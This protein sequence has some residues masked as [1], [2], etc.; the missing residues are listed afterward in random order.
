VT[1]T[2][3]SPQDLGSLHA[4]LAEESAD[5]APVD[6]GP[7]PAAHVVAVLVAHDGEQWLR[8][9]LNSVAAQTR[10][11]DVVIV[12]D[13]G[14]LDATPDLLRRAQDAGAVDHVL[15]VGRAVGFGEAVRCALELPEAR[16]AGP[17]SWLWMLHD[18]CAAA[19]SALEELLRA[20]EISSGA[21]VLGPKVVDWHDPRVLVEVGVTL[22]RAGHRHTG[23]EGRELDQGQADLTRTVLAVGTAAALVRREVWDALGGLDPAL[24]LFRDDVDLGW[25]VAA[26]GSRCE[27]VPAAVVRHVRAAATGRRPTAAVA[28]PPRRADRRSALWVL[29]ANAGPLGLL[30]VPV[31]VLSTLLRAVGDLVTRRPHHARDEFGA[32]WHLIAALPALRR[33]RAQRAARRTVPVRRVKQLF[34]PRGTSLR[35]R[36]SQAGDLLAGTEDVEAVAAVALETGPGEEDLGAGLGQDDGRRLARLLL[37]PA[38]LIPTGLTLLTLVALRHLLGAGSLVGGRLLPAPP[39]AR[40]LWR[41]WA[42]TW[43]P[44]PSGGSGTPSPPFTPWLGL[45]STLTLGR[46]SLAVDLLVLGAVPMAGLVAW[47]ASRPLGIGPGL[48]TW[49]ALTWA[50]SPVATGAVSGGRFDLCVALVFLPWMISAGA[51]VLTADPYL[52]GWRRTWSLALLLAMAAAFHPP[53]WLIAAVLGSV[54]VLLTPGARAGRA[55]VLAVLL[56]VPVLL[57]LPW[58][59]ALAHQPLDLLVGLGRSAGLST[60]AS[61]D[62]ASGP[63]LALLHPGGPGL[64]WA[65][66]TLPLLLAAVVALGLPARARRLAGYVAVATALVGLA[67]AV[68]VSR[69]DSSLPGGEQGYSWP[70]MGIA[71]A[72]LGVLAAAMLAG[73]GLRGRMVLRSFSLRTVAQ[74]MLAATCA[75]VPLV[76]AG[77]W[78]GQGPGGAGRAQEVGRRTIALLPPDVQADAAAV[79]DPGQRVLVLQRRADGSLRYDLG[80]LGGPLLGD[81]DRV[82]PTRSRRLLDAV[83]RDLGATRG[84]DADEVLTTFDIRTVVVSGRMRSSLTDALDSQPSL[85]RRDTPYNISLWQVILP[86][87]RAAVLAPALASA[88][89]KPAGVGSASGRGPDRAALASTPPTLL[90]VGGQDV[91]ARIPAGEPGRL[92]VLS[93]AIS[94]GWRATLDGHP[95]VPTLAWG[96][97]QGF[98]LPTAG[99]RLEVSRAEGSHQLLLVLQVLGLLVVLV[100]ALPSSGGDDETLAEA[101]EPAPGPRAP[102]LAP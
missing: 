79:G 23:L 70:G 15:T 30:G 11:P 12:V 52:M 27:I 5:F 53:L 82:I 64:P 21:S 66:L 48:R 1:V 33:A 8:G 77:F 91:R 51:R 88:A 96:W 94:G 90:R 9:C 71:L 17:G 89:L 50:L 92:L 58:L 13:T 78:L 57:A 7:V 2:E 25:R 44:G 65:P 75:V 24:P 76:L 80:R 32:A 39:G 93:E 101:I 36:I 10:V 83:V 72:T 18:D 42:G 45:L 49:A 40:D 46:P 29:V 16:S 56:G 43:L 37:R 97:A 20:G 62:V 28:G 68:L 31:L 54:T 99:G 102:E 84:S 14:S 3:P 69:V 41:A 87:G 74:P 86:V 55:R 19:P 100:L 47:H 59:P 35:L 34:A 98:H 38:V 95:L 85:S 81:E 60:A 63:E 6:R 4:L 22:D 73:E 67:G 26:A 61:R